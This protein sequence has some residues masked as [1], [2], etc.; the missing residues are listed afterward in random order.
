MSL[1][2]LIAW[3]EGQEGVKWNFLT[4]QLFS[5]GIDAL[6][7]TSILKNQIMPC[8]VIQQMFNTGIGQ[9]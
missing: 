9:K 8:I 4:D 1:L 3:L 5:N 6:N 7:Q 2:L